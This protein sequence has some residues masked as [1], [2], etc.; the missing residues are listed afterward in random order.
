[1][2][3][4]SRAGK[5]AG[6]ISTRISIQ[7][8]TD[9]NFVRAT[10]NDTTSRIAMPE[11]LRNVPGANTIDFIGN[12]LSRLVSRKKGALTGTAKSLAVKHNDGR[13]NYSE[14]TSKV[15][16]FIR[17]TLAALAEANVLAM[18]TKQDTSELQL[19][20]QFEAL[21]SELQRYETLSN[22]QQDA[23]EALTEQKAELES[24]VEAL[25]QKNQQ[26]DKTLTALAATTG[27][28]TTRAEAAEKAAVEAKV[29]IQTQA[30]EIARLRQQLAEAKQA[31]Q[32]RTKSVSFSTTGPRT[33]GAGMFA[34]ESKRRPEIEEAKVDMRN[35]SK[36]RS[37]IFRFLSAKL[38]LFIDLLCWHTR[39]VD[40]N[41]LGGEEMDLLLPQALVEEHKY[42]GA[43]E[44]TFHADKRKKIDLLN[45]TK[46]SLVTLDAFLNKHDLQLPEL[47]ST[48]INHQEI[49]KLVISLI[50]GEISL[51]DALRKSCVPQ[52]I[53]QF[54]QQLQKAVQLPDTDYVA[55]WIFSPESVQSVPR[56]SA[57]IRHQVKVHTF[58]SVCGENSP[59]KGMQYLPHDSE[60]A[61]SCKQSLRILTQRVRDIK[62]ARKYG[63]AATVVS[64]TMGFS[65]AS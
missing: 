55:G 53:K 26:Q 31:A 10:Y 54:M 49:D 40:L 41:R 20:E 33:S 25:T 24:Q 4:R 48:D 12:L 28:L 16:D 7:N 57:L 62:A 29:T 56:T 39:G 38:T 13:F 1:M 17:S 58:G 19:Q 15:L 9:I 36:Q 35:V 8:V 34:V 64:T 2:S 50:K 61:D 43:R 18:E 51:V 45:G 11:G 47:S 21:T 3:R 5:Q 60:F 37:N 14:V 63:K 6:Y 59:E 42:G 44:I 23:L 30:E 65:N 22:E 46:C 52:E 27:Q 32:R